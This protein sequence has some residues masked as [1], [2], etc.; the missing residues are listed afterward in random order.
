MVSSTLKKKSK[1]SLIILKIYKNNLNLLLDIKNIQKLITIK[2][3]LLR[4]I[5]MMMM[6]I[7]GNKTLRSESFV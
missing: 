7:H 2:L 1:I 5:V 3:D 4:W 6:M